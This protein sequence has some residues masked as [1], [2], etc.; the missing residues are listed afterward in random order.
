VL[1]DHQ[2]EARGRQG[3]VRGVGFDQGELQT[4]LLLA[5][6]RRVQLRRGHIHGD[7]ARTSPHEPGREERRAATQLEDVQSRDVT[8]DTERRLGDAEE[9][10]PDV[11]GGPLPEG[12]LVGVLS[13]DERSQITVA[14][15]LRR[16]TGHAASSTRSR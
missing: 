12:V 10:P 2:I 6:T 14:L 11:V 15:G 1:A 5:A 3:D 16:G 7:R 4:V 9:A 13:V 8:E